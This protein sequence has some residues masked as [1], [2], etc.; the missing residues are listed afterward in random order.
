MKELQKKIDQLKIITGAS[1]KTGWIKDNVAFYLWGLVK[2]YDP[3]LVLNIGHL[4][5]KSSMIFCDAM[6]GNHKLESEYDVGDHEFKNFV[7]RGSIQYSKKKVFSVD[8]HTHPAGHRPLNC[9]GG[10]KFISE[11]YK[12]FVFFKKRSQDFLLE[13]DFSAYK[14]KFA[15]IDGDHSYEGARRDVELCREHGFDCI[16]VDDTEYIPHI[17]KATHDGLA[18]KYKILDIPLWNGIVIAIKR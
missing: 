4:W 3:D 18:G 14:R 8:P 17:K 1:K 13:S 7:E 10:V 12:D 16:V 2:L 5:G 11:T 15:F 6:F 9:E